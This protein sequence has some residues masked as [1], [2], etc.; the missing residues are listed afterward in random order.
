MSIQNYQNLAAF[1]VS[2]PAEGVLLVEMNRPKKLNAMNPAFWKE[3]PQIM[4]QAHVDPLVRCVVLTGGDSRI[5]S[6]G[7]DLKA[8]M[9]SD[10]AGALPMKGTSTDDVGRKGMKQYHHIRP[11]Q[12]SFTAIEQCL[13]P[14]IVCVHGAC[15]GGGMDLISACDIRLCSADA[16]FCIKEVDVGLAADVGT[17]QRLPKIIGN[18]SLIRELTYTA[19]NMYAKEA[20]R[21]GLVSKVCKDKA[22]MMEEAVHMASVIA[23]KSPIAV[24][25]S[26]NLTR[27][28]LRHRY[29]I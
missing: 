16:R 26:N 25:G 8:M 28:E 19:R 24:A 20:L 5:F 23:S 21:C 14:V 17:L 22:T 18:D 3:L 29:N 6:A 13:K 15:I 1:R 7:L 12:G 11:L 9:M 2:N 27:G 10:A 4:K